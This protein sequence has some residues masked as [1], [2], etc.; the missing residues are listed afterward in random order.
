[1]DPELEY[2]SVLPGNSSARLSGSCHCRTFRIVALP[3]VLS[4]AAGGLYCQPGEG[5]KLLRII[6]DIT[7]EICDR[8]GPDR[9]SL[10]KMCIPGICIENGRTE[11]GFFWIYADVDQM[12]IE[13]GLVEIG[14]KV[15]T[16]T[17]WN[18]SMCA[19]SRFASRLAQDLM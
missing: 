4:G 5:R 7:I 18:R 13:N 11:L 17:S 14:I 15:H 19:S 1:M 8:R 16:E 2:H 12:G 3:L 10:P 6:A 9:N